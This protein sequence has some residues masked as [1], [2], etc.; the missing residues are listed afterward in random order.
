METSNSN[1]NHVGLHAQKD[2]WGLGPIGTNNSGHNVAF[3]NAQNHRC[4][5]PIET[6]NSGAKVSNSVAKVAV[7][8]E[9]TISEVWDP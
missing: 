1:A 5:A 9:K 3:V 8:N 6:C 2:R 4:V 7:L